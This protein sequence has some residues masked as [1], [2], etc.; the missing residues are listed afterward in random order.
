M[1]NLN[2]MKKNALEQYERIALE[3]PYEEVV[4][5]NFRSGR[6]SALNLVWTGSPRPTT[7]IN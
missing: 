3:E 7:L 6:L 5:T 4:L 1:L 2:I